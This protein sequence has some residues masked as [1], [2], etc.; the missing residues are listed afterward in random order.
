MQKDKNVIEVLKNKLLQNLKNKLLN[1]KLAWE[2]YL[3]LNKQK[4]DFKYYSEY[5]FSL[6]PFIHLIFHL[7]VTMKLKFLGVLGEQSKELI[8][9]LN[10]YKIDLIDKFSGN[11]TSLREELLGDDL[12]IN[13]HK[14]GFYNKYVAIVSALHMAF[15]YI[16]NEINK[17]KD[18][19]IK[20]IKQN[21]K[22]FY[23]NKM[24][25][26]IKRILYLSRYNKI[27]QFVRIQNNKVYLMDLKILMKILAINNVDEVPKMLTKV[28]Q[29]D[30]LNLKKN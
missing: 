14:K 2:T 28:Y 16:V 27:F 20:Y 8:N 24:I 6:L 30:L 10:Q 7:N 22:K 19:Y 5:P 21:I 17:T 23:K 26:G 4:I 12:K 13:P 25:L 3:I 9:N 1:G 15:N 18:V 29:I 11:S